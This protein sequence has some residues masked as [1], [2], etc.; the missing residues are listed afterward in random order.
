MVFDAKTGESMSKLN[1]KGEKIRSLSATL[2]LL[3]SHIVH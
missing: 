3:V 2:R 1:Q